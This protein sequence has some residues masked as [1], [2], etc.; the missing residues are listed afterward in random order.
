MISISVQMPTPFRCSGY[1]PGIVG[2]DALGFSQAP[3]GD[4]RQLNT[5]LGYT[6][7]LSYQPGFLP[8]FDGGSSVYFA[9]STTPRGAYGDTGILL[10]RS[11]LTIF[12]TDFRYHVP[13]AV[14]REPT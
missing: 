12:E 2:I 7:R 6:F 9:P 11:S 10:G 13:P 14:S 1:A 4:F 3:L 8:G 5:Y